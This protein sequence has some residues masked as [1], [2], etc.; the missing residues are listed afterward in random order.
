MTIPIQMWPLDYTRRFLEERVRLH[1]EARGE[2]SYA[3]P[4]WPE[5]TD[6]E[7]WAKPTTWAVQK[8]G[9]KKAWRVFNSFMTAHELAERSNEMICVERPGSNPKCESY[10]DVRKF[11]DQADHLGVPKKQVVDDV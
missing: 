8:P 9:A 2:A 5:C 4:K 3:D 11:C 10:C 6:E 1:Q 7:R